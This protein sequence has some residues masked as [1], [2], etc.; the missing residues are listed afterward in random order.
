[1]ENLMRAASLCGS[2]L[3]A[4]CAQ[5]PQL[6]SGSP[7]AIASVSEGEW[8]KSDLHIHSRHSKDSSNNPV[9]TIIAF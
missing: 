4:S 3:L 5:A 2:L 7:S 6:V 9:A 8:L 1:M